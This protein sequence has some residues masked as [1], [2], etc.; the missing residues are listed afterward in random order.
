MPELRLLEAEKVRAQLTAEQERMIRQLYMQAAMSVR[1]WSNSLEGRDNI[2]SILRREYL[3]QLERELLD[4]LNQAGRTVESMIRVNMLTTATAVVKDMNSILNSFG[5]SI[6]TAYSFVPSDVVQSIVTGRIYEG[7]WSLSQAIWGQD[8]KLQQDIQNIIAQGVAENRSS[9]EI[10]KELE[11]YVNPT[12]AKPWNWGRVYPGTNRIVDYNAQR[13]ARTMVSHAYQQS[14]MQTT[15][16]NPFFEGY[17]WLTANNH[18]VCPLCRGYAEDYHG[19]GLP[20]GV[21]PKEDL[22]LDHPNGQCTF[23]VYMTQTTDQI[24]DALANWAHGQ[25]SEELDA[26]AESLGFPI[27]AVKAS[28]E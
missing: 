6:N 22:P 18:K 25:P 24:V 2:S 19:N 27:D 13:L 7:N 3:A 15:R 17:H 11:Q 26:F 12:A 10:A 5:I 9:Y 8:K 20:A 23:S 14:F 28:I 16:G 4:E 1:E 21:F